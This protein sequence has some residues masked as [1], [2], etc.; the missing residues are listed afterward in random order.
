MGDQQYDLHEYHLVKNIK[1]SPKKIDGTAIYNR[2]I[3]GGGKEMVRGYENSSSVKWW[4]VCTYSTENSR[5]E[6]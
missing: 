5:P 3:K 2:W 1:I 4:T 6:T